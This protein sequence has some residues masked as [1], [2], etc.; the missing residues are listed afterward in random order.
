MDE[1]L[2]R[3]ESGETGE[4]IARIKAEHLVQLGLFQHERLI[5]LIVTVLFAVLEFMA[6]LFILIAEVLYPDSLGILADKI[7]FDKDKFEDEKYHN[8]Y[9][10]HTL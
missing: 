1:L 8:P 4:D 9:V 3:L 7:L 10:S 6:F 5:H 2:K